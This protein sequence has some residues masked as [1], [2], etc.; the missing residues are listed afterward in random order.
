MTVEPRSPADEFVRFCECLNRY[1]VDYVIV[2]SEAVAFHGAPRYSADFDTFVRA[3]RANLFRVVAALE[4]FGAAELARTIDPEVWARS[5]ATVRLGTPPLQMD[6]LLQLSGVSF[7]RVD[8]GAVAGRYGS[9]TVRFIG[10]ED[11]LENKRAAGRPKDLADVA[12]LESGGTDFRPR[13]L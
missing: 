3:T 6:V 10:L 2:G 1:D 9:A 7:D 11:L 8:R 13:L 4:A 5:G 12:A